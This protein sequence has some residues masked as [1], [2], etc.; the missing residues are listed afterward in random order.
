MGFIFILFLGSELGSELLF[1]FIPKAGNISYTSRAILRLNGIRYISQ[2]PIFGAGGMLG[3]LTAKQI[4]PHELPLRMAC[5]FGI[6]G[7]LFTCYLIYVLPV[8]EFLK[9][10]NKELIAIVA[11]SI[12]VMVSITNNYTDICLFWLLY[13]EAMCIFI[14]RSDLDLW[15]DKKIRVRIC[16]RK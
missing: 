3:F 13:A 11:Y 7:S 15:K 1:Y 8:M 10:K 4:D 12:V 14:D 9:T 5:L 2:N 6:P 16:I